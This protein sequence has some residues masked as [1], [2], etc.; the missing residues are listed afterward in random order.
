MRTAVI[1]NT[2][3]N[4]PARIFTTR[5]LYP[6]VRFSIKIGANAGAM[7]KVAGP[8]VAP[9]SALAHSWWLPLCA[10]LSIDTPE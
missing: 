4:S 8:T 3:D 9:T 2:T 5:P 6:F 7:V 10:A 1:N